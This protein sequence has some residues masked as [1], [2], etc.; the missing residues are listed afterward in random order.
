MPT[1]DRSPVSSFV[2]DYLPALLA[3]ASHFISDEFHSVV[4]SQGLSVNE[5]RVLA[6]LADGNLMSTG[7][8]A[9]V[10]LTTQPTVTRVIDRLAARGEV[11]RVDDDVDRRLTLVQITAAGARIVKRL[12]ALAREHEA[13]V[14]APMGPHRAAELKHALRALVSEHA[15]GTFSP[16]LK[17]PAPRRSRSQ[18]G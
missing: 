2:D 13:R 7:E 5:W 3:L 1:T 8:L 18:A 6:C 14:L 12:S 4:R 9:R 11:R 10:S 16:A 15:P 17:T